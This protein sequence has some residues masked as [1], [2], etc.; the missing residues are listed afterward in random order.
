MYVFELFMDI[1]YYVL[2]VTYMLAM[3]TIYMVDFMNK[4]RNSQDKNSPIS[5]ILITDRQIWY[6]LHKC[7][8]I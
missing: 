3:A 8:H 5:I 2:P 1:Y 6:N 4:M 7:G